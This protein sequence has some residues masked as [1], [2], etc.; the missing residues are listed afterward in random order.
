MKIGDIVRLKEEHHLST[1]LEGP[2]IVDEVRKFEIRVNR[3][4]RYHIK[5][6][7][8][9]SDGSHSMTWVEEQEVISIS[10]IRQERLKEL[11]I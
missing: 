1:F 11:G 7:N 3:K 10:E 6:L 9:N 5:T 4:N 2:C 8:K